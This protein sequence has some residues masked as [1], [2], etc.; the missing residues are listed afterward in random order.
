MNENADYEKGRHLVL[1]QE[2]DLVGPRSDALMESLRETGYS[3]PDA[4]A[5]LIDNYLSVEGDET[6]RSDKEA[7]NAG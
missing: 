4:I 3:L 6:P 5:D 7:H 1:E 2:Y